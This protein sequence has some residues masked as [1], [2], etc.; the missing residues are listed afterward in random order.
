[1]RIVFKSIAVG[2]VAAFAL[3]VLAFALAPFFD[4]V[5]FY[6]APFGLFSP[7][8]DRIPSTVVDKLIPNR[9]IPDNGPAAGVAFILSAVLLFWT[10]SFGALYFVWV[11]RR[12]KRG[13]SFGQ[14][15]G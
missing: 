8:L 13:K 11:I 2:V 7:I 5:G 14:H 9:L 3:G 12:R 4:A 15:A 10:L 1:M 6:I